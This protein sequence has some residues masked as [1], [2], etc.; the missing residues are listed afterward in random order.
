[1]KV[2]YLGT[3]AVLPCFSYLLREHEILALY[4]CG[5]HDDYFREEVI[6]RMAET[7]GIPVHRETID[8][9]A[10]RRYIREGCGLFVSADYGRK[11]PVLPEEEGFFGVNIHTSFL[12]EGRSYCPVECALERGEREIGVTVHK[13]SPEFDR[14]DILAQE[15][16]PIP[17]DCDSV[18]L[19]LKSASVARKLLES[20]LRDFPAAWNGAEPQKSEGSYWRIQNFP[21]A[22]LDHGMSVAE[23]RRI[24]RIYNRMTRVKIGSDVYFITSLEPG[25]A[26][27]EYDVLPLGEVT[28][29]RLRDGHL[30]LGLHKTDHP[31]EVWESEKYPL[32]Y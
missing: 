26:Q 3:D 10:E 20:I 13:L 8:E 1:M 14:G 6:R 7:A 17:E 19:Y 4:I 22:R 29:Y 31:R 25:A 28:L 32:S 15:R 23:A 9:E 18:D 30:R 5:N 27:I 11:I 2:V 12:P 24:Y 21:A 16:I